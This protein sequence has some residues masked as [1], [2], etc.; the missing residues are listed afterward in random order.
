MSWCVIKRAC[1]SFSIVSLMVKLNFMP[2]EMS[3]KLEST[4][5]ISLSPGVTFVNTIDVT[6]EEKTLNQKI[7]RSFGSEMVFKSK[8]R[9]NLKAQKRFVNLFCRCIIVWLWFIITSIH[10]NTKHIYNTFDTLGLTQK[11]SEILV[12]DTRTILKAA[13]PLNRQMNRMVVQNII[14][15]SHIQNKTLISHCIHQ[16]NQMWKKKNSLVVVP[17]S[18]TISTQ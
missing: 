17:C 2:W 5:M 11:D 14:Q 16:M 15:S 12:F 18:N 8:E 6:E 3:S 7:D 10:S 13:H 1:R 4:E 9:K